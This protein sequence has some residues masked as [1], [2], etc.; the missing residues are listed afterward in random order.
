MDEQLME[1]KITNSAEIKKI[2]NF[3]EWFV[4]KYPLSSMTKSTVYIIAAALLIIIIIAKHVLKTVF[5]FELVVLIIHSLMFFIEGYANF[6]EYIK[7]SY[8]SLTDHFTDEAPSPSNSLLEVILVKAD[9]CPSC[10]MYINSGT[11]QKVVD[12]IM[13]DVSPSD[14][15]FTVYD[16]DK[17]PRSVIQNKLK[18]DA[19][20][21]TYIPVVYVRTPDGVFLYKDN[22]YDS[23]SMIS[24]LLALID[25]YITS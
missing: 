25:K 4:K 21:I 19:S 16:I 5:E 2:P 20:T 10:S 11:W 13:N 24:V 3:A 17:T 8:E 6:A 18:I 12:R 14:L 15:S 7:Q 1:Q 9:W 23:D 22:V